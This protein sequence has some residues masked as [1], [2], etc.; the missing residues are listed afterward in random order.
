LTT[1][2]FAVRIGTKYDQ[3]VEDYINSK[4]PNVTWIRDEVDGMR[5]QWNKLRVMNMDI[6][7]PVLVIDIDMLFINDYMKAIEYPIKRGE[8]LSAKSWWKDTKKG[9]FSLNGGFQKYYPKDCKYIYDEFMKKPQYWMNYFI[10]NGVTIGEVNGEQFFVET[11]VKRKLNLKFLP[12]SWFFRYSEDYDDKNHIY[13]SELKK[14]KIYLNSQN[15][16]YPGGWAYLGG[17]FNDSIKIVHFMNTD[18]NINII[19]KYDK[20]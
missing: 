3:S 5:L 17:E 1:K 4:L 18:F 16:H 13:K 8:F 6:D 15:S 10:E 19:K 7:E 20:N 9:N 12:T 2:I 11:M 14:Y